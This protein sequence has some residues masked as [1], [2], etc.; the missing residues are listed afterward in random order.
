M[1][2]GDKS[3]IYHRKKLYLNENGLL[4]TGE[5]IPLIKLTGEN[6]ESSAVRT[7]N[8]KTTASKPPD[9]FTLQVNTKKKQAKPLYNIAVT[10]Y[11]NRD[12]CSSFLRDV[13]DSKELEEFRRLL[14]KVAITKPVVEKE[15]CS[16]EQLVGG[17]NAT[18][19]YEEYFQAHY[20]FLLNLQNNYVHLS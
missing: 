10:N 19:I 1:Q 20:D 14:N 15:N 16:R 7:P 5:K 4:V 8:S 13:Y 6:R 2:S 11:K 12:A 18:K 9:A 17:V 3:S